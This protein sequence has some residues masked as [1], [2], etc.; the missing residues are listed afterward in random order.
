MFTALSVC[1]T[2]RRWQVF[3]KV[4]TTEDGQKMARRG[5]WTVA[6]KAG[7]MVKRPS[8]IGLVHNDDC[9]AG[10]VAATWLTAH[11]WLLQ[12]D[13]HGLD[14]SQAHRA[15]P[16]WG[17]G[18]RRTTGHNLPGPKSHNLFLHVVVDPQCSQPPLSFVFW[19]GLTLVNRYSPPSTHQT[20][21]SIKQL[22]GCALH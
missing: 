20:P 6:M 8:R 2:D 15:Q 7:L 19:L 4:N 9:D 10:Q 18:V 17:Q 16:E 3:L 14:S 22:I 11:H 5:E 12:Q 1:H 13:N 21:P